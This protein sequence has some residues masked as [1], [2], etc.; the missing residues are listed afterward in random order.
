MLILRDARLSPLHL[1][2]LLL[3]AVILRLPSL[4]A[5]F[6]PQD[7]SVYHA[8]A[9][10][11][12]EGHALY[13]DT[14]EHKPP[15]LL[16]LYAGIY[17]LA[18]EYTRQVVAILGMVLLTFAALLTA[19]LCNRFRNTSSR[20][21]WPAFL[22]LVYASEPWYTQ[23]L[24]AEL[25]LLVPLLLLFKLLSDYA[26]EESTRWQRL[27]WVGLLAA[28]IFW[29]KYQALLIVLTC[30]LGF[31]LITP[32]RL[33]VLFTLFAG[34]MLG[35]LVV[36]LVLH[37]GG[38]LMGWWQLGLLFNLDYWLM[39]KNPG[40]GTN[41]WSFLEYLK[42]W[43]VPI[44]VCVVAFLRMRGLYFGLAIRERRQETLM[45]FW[46]VGGGLALL[47]GGQRMYL[48]YFLLLLPPVLFYFHWFVRDQLPRILS[49][50]VVLLSL[51]VPAFTH[52][53]YYA[54][55]VPQLYSRLEPQIRPGGWLQQLHQTLETDP[56]PLREALKAQGVRSIW[57][58]AF[59][60]QWYIRLGFAPATPY[61]NF[62][63]A[64][65]R[66][67]WLEENL[68][69]RAPFS[70]EET[71]EQVYDAFIQ[72]PPDAVLDPQG[73]FAEMRQRIYWLYRHYRP[74]TV[75]HMPLWLRAQPSE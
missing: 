29:T 35:S 38:N 27:F 59:E 26:L 73:Y 64:R 74:D 61:V 17:Q 43:G 22:F 75:G 65:V 48:H 37:L 71:L 13:T 34:F 63:M 70:G 51:L 57:V 69:A 66:M 6:L 36:V 33:Q 23:E 4:D 25:L 18:G 19:A 5:A 30:I 47:Q 28:I 50:V 56:A 44:L 58:A 14:W 21:L 8:V 55:R 68:R 7:Q 40:D 49:T 60:P 24:N 41:W 11:L 15:L 1:L 9:M 10:R 54:A 32:L 67:L 31:V 2:L 52:A 16:W 12:A 20:V 53:S 46:L 42:I 3:A 45:A 62:N 39:G 72:D